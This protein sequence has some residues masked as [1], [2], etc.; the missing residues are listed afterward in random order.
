[1]KDEGTCDQCI[2]S[3][4][5][6]GRGGSTHE[7]AKSTPRERNSDLR[8]EY[9]TSHCSHAAHPRYAKSAPART[10]SRKY[11]NVQ[12]AACGETRNELC[13][14]PS[15]VRETFLGSRIRVTCRRRSME[16]RATI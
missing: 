14:I 2:V 13:D 16:R 4:L 10:S 11:Y 5:S 1:M 8:D 6:L 12:G 7:V 9:S 15:V 3:L